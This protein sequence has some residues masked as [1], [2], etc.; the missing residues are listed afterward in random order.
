MSLLQNSKN[1]STALARRAWVL[2]VLLLAAGSASANKSGIGP[3]KVSLPDGPGSLG[4]VGENADI[5]LNMGV[6][7]YGVPI[8]VPAGR[9]GGMTPS[10]RLAYSSGGGSSMVGMGW[11]LGLPAIERMTNQGL[12]TYNMSDRFAAGGELVKIPGTFTYR[13]RYEGS[14]ER[15]TWVNPQGGTEGYWKTEHT[16]GR[17]SYYGATANGT[18]QPNARVQGS[19]GTFRY[20]LCETVDVFGHRVRY[21]Y[22]KDNGTPLPSRITYV[23]D[24]AGNPRYEI[25]LTYED[26][27]DHLSDGKSGVEVKITQRLGQVQVKA[28]GI[29]RS[30]FKLQYED[31]G[32]SGGLTRLVAVETFGLNDAGPFP[33]KF[34]FA[35]TGVPLAQCIGPDC[36][37]PYVHTMGSVGADFKTGNVD[38]V[39]LNGDA[40]PDVLNTQGGEHIIHINN[41]TA[42]GD[43]QFRMGRASD[44]TFGTSA[45]LSGTEVHMLDLNGDGFSDMIDGTNHRVLW[46]NG[47]GDWANEE[48]LPTN[49]PSFDND[50]NLSFFDYNGDRNIDIVHSDTVNT[51]YYVNNGDGSY[52][53]TP[54]DGEPI[55]DSFSSGI[56]RMSDMNGDG[57]QDP[58]RVTDG[59]NISYRLNLGWGNW[60][61]RIAMDWDDVSG[62]PADLLGADINL[63]DLNGDGLDDVVV[64]QGSTISYALN[65]NGKTFDPIS[66]ITSV[67]VDGS[68]PER[69]AEVSVRL[70][71]MNGSGSTDIVWINASGLVTYL[72]LF[73]MRPNLLNRIDNSIGKV[74]ELRYGSSVEHM[75]RDGGPTAWTHRIPHP[76]LVVDQM[77]TYDTMSGNKDSKTYE[78]RNGFYDGIEKQFRGFAD[79]TVIFPGDTSIEDGRTIHHFDVGETDPY[80]K[81]RMLSLVAESG[82]RVL[83][84]VQ[85]HYD[86]CEVAGV[87]V[88]AETP[89]RYVC[90]VGTTEIIKEDRPEAEWVTIAKTKEFDGYGNVTLESDHGIVSIGGQGCG[91]CS[92]ADDVTGEPCG[93]SCQGDEKFIVT[94]YV[95][96]ANTGGRWIPGMGYRTRG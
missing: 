17:I 25:L 45:V 57:L 51:W 27:A 82:G 24:D 52:S 86:D 77:D 4:G 96:L 66:D 29:Q 3:S 34:R 79:T 94:D 37:T 67:H 7:G 30:R 13:N 71:D 83:K 43:H 38:L 18:L 14:F 93:Q 36:R 39:D 2:A 84:E 60:G 16:D 55:E 72:E 31:Y 87:P 26:R 90:Q 59:G 63:T 76:M 73:P 74:I 33:I 11:S 62:R 85:N 23:F 12:P 21:E 95:D 88:I 54:V 47:T 89:I 56:L 49:F 22:T 19:G 41:L 58:V 10:L 8:G 35:Y 15:H 92:R 75:A 42:A 69:T 32:T 44:T 81:G 9:S 64:I 50:G 6:M 5:D 61:S 91:A 28:L 80:F 40:L 78:Y 70:A 68:I 46:N 65:R 20:H 53:P 48:S 1:T